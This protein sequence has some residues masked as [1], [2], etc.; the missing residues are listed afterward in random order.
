MFTSIQSWPCLTIHPRSIPVD[1]TPILLSFL[2]VGPGHYDLLIENKTDL[3]ST[4]SSTTT[5]SQKEI[6]VC[7]CG[8][9][10]NVKNKQKI[11]CSKSS[12]YAS[13]RPC[14]RSSKGCTNLCKCQ[15]C[16]N[17]F[18]QASISEIPEAPPCKKRR[19]WP[20][21]KEQELKRSTSIKYMQINGE[22][23]CSGRWTPTEHYILCAIIYH[24]C[25]RKVC[26]LGRLDTISEKYSEILDF[27][28]KND[29][30]LS[31]ASKSNLQIKSKLGQ[32]CK[33]QET[34]KACHQINILPV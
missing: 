28:I 1:S 16:D 25:E 17:P 24:E 13:R 12:K 4:P 15:N 21:H 33:D 22:Q 9:G 31:L 32:I 34:S 8:R 11:N 20:K 26:D 29:I 7:Q 14:L 2:Q 19:C 27:M 10:R 6:V 23:P 5:A 18:G 3:A 30:P